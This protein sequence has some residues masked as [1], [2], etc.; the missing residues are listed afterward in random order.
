M[1]NTRAQH[2]KVSGILV[3]AF[4]FC[5]GTAVTSALPTCPGRPA[6]TLNWS[7]SNCTA[8]G[9][10]LEI[11]SNNANCNFTPL[12][13]TSDTTTIPAGTTCTVTL[14]C[15]VGGTTVLATDSA[16]L[17]YDP[18][19]SWDGTN[20]VPTPVNAVCG[21]THYS[22]AAGRHVTT[23]G[24]NQVENASAWSWHCGGSNGGTDAINC[25]E[26]KP[27]VGTA[28]TVTMSPDVTVSYNG[29][30][31]ASFS[32]SGGAT[33]CTLYVDSPKDGTWDTVTPL[34]VTSNNWPNT[35]PHTTTSVS[36]VRC[37]NSY[38][39]SPYAYMTVTVCPASTPNWNGTSCQ[40]AVVTSCPNGGTPPTCT[41]PSGPCNII[42]DFWYG[43]P[44][45]H[46]SCANNGSNYP[47]CFPPPNCT[48]ANDTRFGMPGCS[49]NCTNGNLN[50]PTCANVPVETW[51][52]ICS[53][54]GGMPPGGA[55]PWTAIQMSSLTYTWKLGGTATGCEKPPVEIWT[56]YCTGAPT[57][58]SRQSSNW[59]GDRLGGSGCVNYPPTVA[60]VCNAA[61]TQATLSW[62][63]VPG[64]TSYRFRDIATSNA[65]S[66]SG[67]WQFYSPYIC[68]IASY[69]GTSLTVTTVPHESHSLISN[70]LDSATGLPGTDRW[71]SFT[72]SGPPPTGSITST[73]NCVISDNASTCM[74]TVN[75]TSSNFI[76]TRFLDTNTGI[77]LSTAKNGPLTNVYVAYGGTGF[78]LLNAGSLV[79]IKTSY[80]SCLSSSAWN[81]STCTP[82]ARGGCTNSLCNNSS[83]YAPSCPL[84]LFNFIVSV[85]NCVIS[86]GDS[87]CIITANWISSGLTTP[88]FVDMNMTTDLSTDPTGPLTNVYVAYGGTTFGLYDG[89]TLLDSQT[90]SAVC[91]SSTA[92]NGATC[93]IC[94]NGGCTNNICNN[95]ALTA[96][97]CSD[98]PVGKSFRASSGLCV[99]D[100][101]VVSAIVS[102]EFYPNPVT[103]PAAITLTCSDSS[104]YDVLN[105]LTN[106]SLIGGPQLYTS[107]VVYTPSTAA[108]ANYILRCIYGSLSN[109]V[110]RT[111]RPTPPPT[112]VR[113]SITPTTVNK[114]EKVVVS[115]NTQYPTNACTFTAK[116][117]CPNNA[118]NQGQT[119]FQTAISALFATTNTD[120]NDPATSRPI[121]TAITKVAPGQMN[122]GW[123][124]LGKKTATFLYTTDVT[125][126]CTATGG[127]KGTKRIQVTK[128]Q[129]E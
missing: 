51:T 116:V 61:G 117:V 99:D 56:D 127:N 35:G 23:G 38:G 77:T 49:N 120:L 114:N 54:W 7:A 30:T 112:I 80:G 44:S 40:A 11:Q 27:S 70:S 87:T 37:S 93:E 62:T 5:M 58:E 13:N 14:S 45:C 46:G 64:V 115:W 79:D 104:Q 128:S 83:S 89:P 92:W 69:S 3:F 125:Y 78:M 85:P 121:I 105:P 81:G 72:C 96:P 53:G 84:S 90:A 15:V 17:T 76:S 108:Q 73:P 94:A 111:Y 103:N 31:P 65:T 119:A 10:L 63:A 75:W 2:R 74:V 67:L 107:P 9:G 124:A 39:T 18:S 52:S 66:C 8:A 109:Q 42:T 123:R 95:T 113:V 34:G 68:R 25:S 1:Y 32:S 59:G 19:Q 28:P 36:A 24:V 60:A 16:T 43:G 22:C 118:C 126:D 47:A 129:E 100:P 86:N 50:Y 29:Y 6:S 102:G 106:T 55:Y 57:F 71:T 110:A 33:A 97:T 21:A 26:A 122:A 4:L 101:Q 48:V 20:C 98:C 12:D 91:D 41:P 82:C 88:R